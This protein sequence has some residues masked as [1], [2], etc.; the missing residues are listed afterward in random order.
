MKQI[1]CPSCQTIL[2][3]GID[4]FWD[5]KLNIHCVHCTQIILATNEEDEIPVAALYQKPTQSSSSSHRSVSHTPSHGV[6]G[7]FS[8]GRNGIMGGSPGCCD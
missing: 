5:E 6:H 3:I 4:Y 2:D 1:R 7:N 8:H